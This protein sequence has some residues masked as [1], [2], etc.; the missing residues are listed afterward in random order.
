MAQLFKIKVFSY[1]DVTFSD[2]HV[3]Y[4][5]TQPYCSLQNCEQ[6][7]FFFHQKLLAH[8][9]LWKLE[10]FHCIQVETIEYW[11]TLPLLYVG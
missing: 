7:T 11:W 6:L 5:K 8:L 4:A 9:I 1:Q 10:D 2:I 3:T